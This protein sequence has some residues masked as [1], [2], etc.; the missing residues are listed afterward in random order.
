[1]KT[2]L[3]ST[4]A[5]AALLAVGAHAAPDKPA[6]AKAHQMS[7]T[8]VSIDDSSLVLSHGM[9]KKQTTFKLTADTKRTGTLNTGSKATVM[10]RDN[11]SEHTATSIRASGTHTTATK[12]AASKPAKS[13]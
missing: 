11:G 8:V 5:L 3:F 1:M 6:A 10:Y 12:P 13:S 7:G 4:V 2:M 9:Y